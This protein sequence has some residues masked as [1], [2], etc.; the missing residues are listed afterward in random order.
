MTAE[1]RRVIRAYED[2]ITARDEQ[3]TALS[4]IAANAGKPRRSL[5]ESF[6]TACEFLSTPWQLRTYGNLECQRLVLRLT[7]FEPLAYCR[8]AGFRAAAIRRATT[9]FRALCAPQL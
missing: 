8:N 6:R 5:E 7:S 2:Q 3:T 1:N 4:E 9:A